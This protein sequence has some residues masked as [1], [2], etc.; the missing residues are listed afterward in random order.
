MGAN[1]KHEAT[2]HGGEH[3]P[4]AIE[5]RVRSEICRVVANASN[6]PTPVGTQMLGRDLAE[7]I[8][9]I[10]E[11]LI[12]LIRE[13]KAEALTE[14]AK[15]VESKAKILD[16]E[17]PT[18]QGARIGLITAGADLTFRANQHKEEANSGR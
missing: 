1:D 15:L 6:W 3:V 17:D 5:R 12:P 8:D 2:Y 16:P 10:T 18:Q 11:A 7:P 14:M 13:A 4:D 9:K